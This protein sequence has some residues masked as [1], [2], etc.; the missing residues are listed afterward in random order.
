MIESD[1]P[2]FSY[3]QVTGTFVIII[4]QPKQFKCFHFDLC[5]P[6][7]HTWFGRS[8]LCESYFGWR[9]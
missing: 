6:V 5:F 4:C 8:V 3:K 1:I 7:A 2:W 9:G